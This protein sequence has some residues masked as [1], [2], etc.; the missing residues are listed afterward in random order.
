MKSYK[1]ILIIGAKSEVSI[2]VARIFASN[3]YD[4]Y[5]FGRGLNSLSPE[6][7]NLRFKYSVNIFC[8]EFDLLDFNSF[9]ASIESLPDLPDIVF[10][11]TGIMYNVNQDAL[12]FEEISVT[13]RTNFEG[14]A[15]F[16]SLI[17]K[18]F[19]NR[20]SGNIIALSSVAGERGRRSNYF[21]GSSK[22]G[23]TAF[24]SGLR[25][26]LF[27]YNIRVITV[28]PGFIKTRMTEG[29]NTP[30]LLT[31]RPEDLARKIYKKYK[32][33]D[34]IYS[35]ILWRWIMVLVKVLPESIFKRINF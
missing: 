24:L 26:A 19:V 22:A 21:Y 11:A 23:L 2:H 28:I 20:G 10:A 18:K 35:S 4:I 7:D 3:G 17:S 32:N 34:I 25:S 27:K 16:L 8:L 14:L 5:L 30:R 1:S 33:N 6:I 9:K 15:L 31:I 29:L 13:L 12:N